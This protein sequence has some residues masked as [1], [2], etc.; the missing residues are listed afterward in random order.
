MHVV[1]KRLT[2]TLKTGAN[3]VEVVNEVSPNNFVRLEIPPFTHYEYKPKGKVLI[4]E[5]KTITRN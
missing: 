2:L 5:S 1:A 4:N 3:P